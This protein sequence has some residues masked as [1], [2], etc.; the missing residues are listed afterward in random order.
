[1]KKIG[2]YLVEG[3]KIGGAWQICLAFLE[4]LKRLNKRKYKIYLFQE[5]N[6]WSQYVSKDIKI[7]KVKRNKY[8][9]SLTTIFS[10]FFNNKNWI[11]YFSHLVDPHIKLINKQNC[12]IIIFPNQDDNSFKIKSKSL[13]TIWDLMHIYEDQFSEYNEKEKLRRDRKYQKICDHSSI[14]VTES[15]TTKKHII[16]NYD[17]NSKKIFIIPLTY[18]QYLNN[19]KNIMLKKNME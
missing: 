1:M 3:K 13:T 6:I 17:I 4:A 16:Q 11:N 8:A 7:V 9:K 2:I 12:D 10:R 18:P 5:E 19:P 15:V 14:V